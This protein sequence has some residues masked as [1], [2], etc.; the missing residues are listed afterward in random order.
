MDRSLGALGVGGDASLEELEQDRS[1]WRLDFTLA[2]VPNDL[3]LNV[4]WP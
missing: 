4:S 2:I 3:E 1:K